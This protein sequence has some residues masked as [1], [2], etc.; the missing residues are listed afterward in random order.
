MQSFLLKTAMVHLGFWQTMNTLVF[1]FLCSVVM[2]F[3]IVHS[4]DFHLHLSADHDLL[5]VQKF[6]EIP[7]PRVGGLGIF[8]ALLCSGIWL[9]VSNSPTLHFFLLLLIPSS[10]A[11]SAGLVED[12]TK[13][14]RVLTRLLVTML[15]ALLGAFLFGASL[16]TFGVAPIDALL[17]ISY[18]SLPFTMVAVGGVAN[19]VNL[20]DGFNGLSGFVSVTAL[21][22]LALVAYLAGDQMIYTVALIFA[23]AVAGFLVWNFPHAKIFLGDGGAYLVGFVIAE[24]SVLLNERN[25]TVSVLFPL[26][27]MIYP[28]FETVFTIYRRICIRGVSPGM[29]DALHL[30]QLINKRLVRWNVRSKTGHFRSRGNAM[31]SPYLWALHSLAAIPAIFF[32]NN[33]LLLAVSIALYMLLYMWLYSRIVCF[34]TPQWLLLR[35]RVASGPELTAPSSTMRDAPSTPVSS[36]R[37]VVADEALFH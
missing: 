30:H 22:A 37:D 21:L 6:H 27:L 2:T 4:S 9:W 16:R 19:A 24:L 34:R 28:I 32:W 25:H 11:F 35:R 33:S 1:S 36:Q 26:L 7:V 17:S 3:L 5:G 18:V 8:L 23:G 29:P 14:V 15:S 31:T 20:I 12:L 10:L 13:R